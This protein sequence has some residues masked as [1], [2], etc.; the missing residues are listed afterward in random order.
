MPNFLPRRHIPKALK[1][2]DSIAL[3]GYNIEI[4][5]AG[6]IRPGYLF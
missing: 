5:E 6:L 1:T 4:V 2:V 3:I